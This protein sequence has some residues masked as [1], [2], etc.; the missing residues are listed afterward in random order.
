M[1][2]QRVNS[3]DPPRL[4]KM[5]RVLAYFALCCLCAGFAGGRSAHSKESRATEHL[6][7]KNVLVL[8]PAN[9]GFE[10]QMTFMERLNEELEAPETVELHTESIDLVKLKDPVKAR[11]LQAIYRTKYRALK[12]DLIIA[13]Q[14]PVLEFL[15]KRRTALFP[16]VPII[17]GMIPKDMPTPAV[18]SPG[19]TGSVAAIDF[20]KTVELALALRPD[21]K[22]VILISGTSARDRWL[23]WIAKEQLRPLAERVH[24]VYW[25]G[26]TPAEAIERFKNLAA[27]D[28]LFYLTESED[29]VGHVYSLEAVPRSHRTG[30]ASPDLQFAG[31]I[32]GTWHRWREP[33]RQRA[34]SARH[35]RAS[36]RKSWLG[37]VRK[38]FRFPK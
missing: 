16:G 8:I 30:V 24:F 26:L 23:Q 13:G 10:G 27:T 20:R 17:F 9:P 31:T 12:F 25:E 22:R 5:T 28:A 37:K 34:R 38:R 6:H 14:R 1:V 19:V 3:D 7:R 36:E 29:R 18:K 35:C 33:V 4:R 2:P 11:E 32:L 21:T 15:L